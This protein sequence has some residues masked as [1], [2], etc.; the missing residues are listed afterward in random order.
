MEYLR[1]TDLEEV[2]Q[3]TVGWAEKYRKLS[4]IMS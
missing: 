2:Q 1:G 3:C 4:E